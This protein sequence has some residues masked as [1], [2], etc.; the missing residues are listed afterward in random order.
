[1]AGNAWE[2]VAD[3]Y[4]PSWKACGTACQGMDPKGP[5]EGRE[6][7]PGHTEKVVRGGS[8]FW[9][10]THATTVYRRPHVPSNRPVFHHFGF[11]CAASV[12]QARALA[13]RS[14]PAL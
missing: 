4:T 5:C 7:C 6:P 1:M 8:W 13:A 14:S 11:R 12:E 2:W 10:A 9:P 3:W